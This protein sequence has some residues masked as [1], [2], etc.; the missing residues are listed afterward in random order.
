MSGD[1]LEWG[2]PAQG[3]AIARNGCILRTVVGSQVHGLNNPGTDDRDEMAIVIEPP[4]FAI[5]LH[6]FEHWS[7]R[8][9]PEG[10]PSGPGDL[11]LVVYSLRRY[12][13]LALK[14]GPTIL[15]PL[16]ALPEHTLICSEYGE[17]LRAVRDLF[18]KGGARS[19]FLGYLEAQRKSLLTASKSRRRELSAEHGYDT[20][21]AMHAV[22]VGYQGLELMH[23]EKL[24]L[25]IPEPKRSRL[26]E[27]RNGRVPLD[28]I[29]TELD[30]LIAQ[31]EVAPISA[32]L[33]PAGVVLEQWLIATYQDYWREHWQPPGLE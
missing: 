24:T 28:E 31:L 29:L 11:D 26:M 9:Q 22:R 21:Y 15:L 18:L 6:H 33:P 16:F 7:Y 27:I 8:T 32:R 20:K 5:G 14:G 30:E 4:E 2:L 1:E 23:D 19:S 12:C 17:R 13:E 3:A 25:P 10:Q